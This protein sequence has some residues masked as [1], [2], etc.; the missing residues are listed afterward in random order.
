M[1]IVPRRE[2]LQFQLPENPE[3]KNSVLLPKPVETSEFR[4]RSRL[5]SLD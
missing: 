2:R 3:Q 1:R 4:K 5:G